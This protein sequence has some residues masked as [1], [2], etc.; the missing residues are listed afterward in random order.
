MR[1]LVFMGSSLALALSGCGARSLEL[2]GDMVERAATCGVV[3]AVDA[4][5]KTRTI[6]GSLP[7]EA[8][9]RIIHY[10]MLT[11][12]EGPAFEPSK[13]AAVVKRMPQL[14]GKVTKGKWQKLVGPCEQAFPATA[15]AS[16]AIEL[17]KDPLEAELGCNGVAAFLDRAVQKP[18]KAAQDELKHYQAMR[19]S[20]DDK[21]G[22]Q[23]KQRG[24][25]S[26]E[27]IQEARQKAMATAVKLGP[28]SEVMKVCL[29]RFA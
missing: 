3:A 22:R 1:S 21:I 27:A 11:A 20:L 17:P 4:R 24:Q 25:R 28:P 14:E 29:A 19:T 13:A 9:S 12:A 26:F 6:Q 18:D 16:G 8:Q 7:L 10:A 5:E 2:P 23:L 15:P